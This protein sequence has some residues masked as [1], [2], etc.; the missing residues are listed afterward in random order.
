MLWEVS[1]GPWRRR[2][3]QQQLKMIRFVNLIKKAERAKALSEQMGAANEVGVPTLKNIDI[4]PLD[5]ETDCPENFRCE[6]LVWDRLNELRTQKI[7]S[8]RAVKAVQAQY[9]DMKKQSDAIQLRDEAIEK[10]VAD[11][12]SQISALDDKLYMSDRNLEIMVQ[13]KQGQNELLQDG[14]V[15]DYS[16][17]VL[18]PQ[19]MVED[20]NDQIKALGA[21]KVRILH[22]IKNF[23]K[24]INYMQWE[25][26]YIKMKERD[27]EE[28]YT[29]LLLLRVE[30]KTL[31]I[32]R[33]EVGLNE[34]DVAVRGEQRM[35]LLKRMHLDKHAKISQVNSKISASIRDRRA[36]NERLKGQLR[37]LEASV[38]ARESIYRSRLDGGGEMSAQ[39]KAQ[40]RMKRVTMRRRLIDL[41]RVQT[42]E[43]DFLRQELDRLRQR[44]FPSFAHAARHRLLLP[45]DEIV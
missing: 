29:D 41:G 25:E 10:E 40:K 37:E 19:K 23:R 42:E 7:Q 8:E 15:T 45:P 34:T 11:V 22:K 13:I 18:I 35:A 5:M 6:D 4:P 38:K 26:N 14:V 31:A 36:E 16:D 1:R 21:E 24:S 44:T 43:I 20:L 2:E 9:N 28:F 17:G 3:R 27:L 39:Q 12:Q 33:G 30:K 32:M